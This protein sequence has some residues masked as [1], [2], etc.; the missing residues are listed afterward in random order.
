LTKISQK[1]NLSQKNK[2][3]L[4]PVRNSENMQNQFDQRAVDELLEQV[5]EKI[6][7]AK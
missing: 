6:G 4:S 3:S 2:I 7:L 1:Y 5:S